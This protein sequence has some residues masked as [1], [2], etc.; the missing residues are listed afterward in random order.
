MRPARPESSGLTAVSAWAVTFVG[1]FLSRDRESMAKPGGRRR[2]RKPAIQLRLEPGRAGYAKPVAGVLA[3]L[4]QFH[5]SF[6]V[7]ARRGDP[8]HRL[9]HI[10]PHPPPSQLVENSE[11]LFEQVLGLCW[12]AEVH[13]HG[14]E[15]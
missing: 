5:G 13:Q 3:S 10:G 12:F 6:D 9:E 1:G 4:R 11:A 15:I 8:S 14:G 2:R 7:G